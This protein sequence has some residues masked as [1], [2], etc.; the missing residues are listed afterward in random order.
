MTPEAGVAAV[1]T[2][3]VVMAME[4]KAVLNDTLIHRR[5]I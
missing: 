2:V 3:M 4:K 1:T 5:L